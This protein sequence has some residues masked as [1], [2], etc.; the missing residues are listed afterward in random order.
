MLTQ[1]R[2]A[3]ID[4]HLHS[5]LARRDLSTWSMYARASSAPAFSVTM[6]TREKFACTTRAPSERSS[7]SSCS[8]TCQRWKGCDEEEEDDE[9]DD[10]D[11]DDDDADGHDDADDDADGHD[12][13]APSSSGRGLCG[14]AR[15]RRAE[16]MATRSSG[17]PRPA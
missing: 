11:D 1:K 14:A 12:D 13:D 6:V 8:H 16:M 5:G 10:H 3:S 9:H 17:T 7:A 4:I 2:L 15:R